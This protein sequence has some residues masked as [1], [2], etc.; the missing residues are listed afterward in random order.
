MKA[1]GE[2]GWSRSKKTEKTTEQISACPLSCSGSL[3]SFE[4]TEIQMA[5]TSDRNNGSDNDCSSFYNHLAN[6]T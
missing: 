3:A 1:G 5:L 2:R 4:K 6:F